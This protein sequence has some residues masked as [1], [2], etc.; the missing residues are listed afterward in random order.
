LET[1][2]N[3]TKIKTI[4]IT[5]ASGGL[6]KEIAIHFSKNG[7]NV[8]ATMISI[9]EADVFKDFPNIN[10]QFDRK[11]IH[12]IPVLSCSSILARVFREEQLWKWSFEEGGR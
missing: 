7:W 8:I 4:L 10:F 3:H 9:K 5:G 12:N 11:A 1:L 2:I 6:G